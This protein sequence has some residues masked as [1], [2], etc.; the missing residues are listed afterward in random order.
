MI[1]MSWRTSPLQ[2]VPL[3]LLRPGLID[4]VFL[5]F[6]GSIGS[7][8]LAFVTQLLCARSLALP[9]YGRLVALLAVINI[10][11]V[12]SGYGVGWFWLQLFGC[13]GRAA[14]R[15]VGATIRL[16]GITFAIGAV[17]LAGY[18]LITSR[19]AASSLLVSVLLIP[20]LFSQALAETTAARLQLEERFTALAAWQLSTQL[21]RFVVTVLLVSLDLAD[22]LHLLAGYA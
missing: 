1:G 11:A 22:L 9:D 14:Y 16:L 4:R 6:S 13:E 18:V 2:S 8:V 7:A 21:G 17:L 10:I 19:D 15:W 12:F 3:G 20:V 5:L